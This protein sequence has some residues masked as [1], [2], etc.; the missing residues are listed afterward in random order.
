MVV[1]LVHLVPLRSGGRGLKSTQAYPKVFG[2]KIVDL[3]ASAEPLT[4]QL[5]DGGL[6]LW[7]DD[8]WLDADMHKVASFLKAAYKRCP[9][10]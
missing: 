10:L 7:D 4:L 3:W 2:E 6:L 1:R 9:W 8:E 5:A